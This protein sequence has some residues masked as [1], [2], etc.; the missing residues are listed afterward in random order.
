MLVSPSD[1]P[2]DQNRWNNERKSKR[3]K[4]NRERVREREKSVVQLCVDI[5]CELVFAYFLSISLANYGNDSYQWAN[6][7]FV[8]LE[9]GQPLTVRSFMLAITNAIT[10]M[11]NIHSLSIYHSWFATKKIRKLFCS[12]YIVVISISAKCEICWVAYI[13]DIA[14]K[15]ARTP[16]KKQRQSRCYDCFIFTCFILGKSTQQLKTETTEIY[17]KSC[18][19]VSRQQ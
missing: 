16:W 18:K 11:T 7:F 9:M 19:L 17:P 1:R 8:A 4:V 15:I 2:T 6:Y 3:N 10:R 13:A 14:I 5:S 12:P